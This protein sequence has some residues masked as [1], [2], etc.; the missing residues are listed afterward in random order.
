M[1]ASA[2]DLGRRADPADQIRIRHEPVSPIDVQHDTVARRSGEVVAHDVASEEVGGGSSERRPI[3]RQVVDRA[4]HL[5]PL[6][7]SKEDHQAVLLNDPAGALPLLLKGASEPSSL[8]AAY[9][10]RVFSPEDPE[11]EPVWYT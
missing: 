6:H 11:V 9:L 7:P 10:V 2:C 4:E 1:L 3:V 5:R 8:G